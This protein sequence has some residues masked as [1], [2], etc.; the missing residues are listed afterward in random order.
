MTTPTNHEPAR[1]SGRRPPSREAARGGTRARILATCR[2]LFN[3]R[4]P[5]AAT[6][7]EIAARVGI[8][9]GNL[10]YHF[11]RKEQI[12]EALFEAFEGSL[13]TAAASYGAPADGGGRF[14]AYLTNWFTVMWEWRFFYRDGTAIF[15]LAPALR[16]RLRTVSD[17]GQ[18]H[19]RR[20]LES[21][22][23]A[24]LVR[25]SPEEIEAV[26]VNA[27]I[28][29]S[30]WIDYLRSRRGIADVRREH[31][32]WGAAQVASLFRPYLTAAGLA[33][34]EGGAAPAAP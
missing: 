17:E 13:R 29:A 24:G 4:G 5:D 26:I 27:W 21:M 11:R 22:R 9:E 28:V 25:A 34:A 7:A 23:E 10:Y 30:Y 1:L 16:P 6:T 18:D 15:R 20:A 12:L 14:G 31:V 32:D 33:L 19:I 8:N 2:D 3:E